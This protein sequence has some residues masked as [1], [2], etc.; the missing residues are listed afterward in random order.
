MWKTR[1][2]ILAAD[3][4]DRAH[5]SPIPFQNYWQRQRLRHVTELT[6][7]IEGEGPVL[8]VGCGSSRIIG[9]LPEG[10]VGVGV[11]LRRLRFGRKFD[12]PL[13]QASGFEL[14]FPDEAFP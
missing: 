2:S 6:E 7:L 3:Y 14:P 1:N 8:D 4:D 5:D 11:L 10:S 12:T 9:A 13:V